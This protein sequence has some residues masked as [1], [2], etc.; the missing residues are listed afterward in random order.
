MAE[1]RRNIHPKRKK[2]FKDTNQFRTISLL[3]V[4]GKIFFSIL[5]KRLKNYLL[6]NN[7]GDTSVP[8]GGLPGISGYIVHTSAISQLLKGARLNKMIWQ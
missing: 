7:Y 3:T 8:K 4:E 2:D 1:S 6:K 5:S